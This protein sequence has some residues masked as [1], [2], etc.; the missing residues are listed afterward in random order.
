MS[1]ATEAV[2]LAQELVALGIKEATADV[3]TAAGNGRAVLVQP[4]VRD[5]RVGSTT[6]T[7]VALSGTSSADLDT[8][9]TLADLV[10]AVAAVAPIEEARP[11]F[12]QLTSDQPPVPAYLMTLTG[13]MENQR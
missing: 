11:G 8:F 3:R 5:Y 6:W 9:Q 13:G 10:D 2:V 4:P 7:L 12:Y 1:M